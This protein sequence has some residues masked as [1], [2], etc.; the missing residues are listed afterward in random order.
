MEKTCKICDQMLPLGNFYF[1]KDTQKYE[2]TCKICRNKKQWK[3]H[4]DGLI[5]HRKV[6]NFMCKK[7]N[8][9]KTS[10]DFFMKDKK[11]TRYDTTCKEC[12]KSSA[13]EWHQENRITSLENKRK[14]HLQNREKNLEKMKSNYRKQMDENPQ[15]VRED[16]R[17]WSEM[18]REK[19]NKKYKDRYN[20]DINFKIGSNLRGG[21]SR[22]I[23]KGYK[24]HCKTIELLDCSVEFVR[25]WL[26]YQFDDHMNWEN[27]GSYWHIDHFV[28]VNYFDL[29]KLEDQMK[30]F[31][32]TNLQ[33]LKKERNLS[34]GAK[35]PT[36]EE[37]FFHF[38]KVNK[39][40]S[41]E[42]KSILPITKGSVIG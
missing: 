40:I 37:R 41:M 15:K 1:R 32:W 4:K 10:S 20:N 9:Q 12:R 6:F 13:K 19:I 23:R 24:K 25:D 31:H 33:P 14:W 18:N 17:R 27:H 2:P 34:K 29:S 30:C 11:A 39:Y 35:L 7:C 26:E 3:R 21:C 22:I 8:Q 36:E 28:P 5:K 38:E 16:K 42:E